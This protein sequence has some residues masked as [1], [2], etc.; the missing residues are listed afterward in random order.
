MSEKWLSLVLAVTTFIGLVFL[1]C[2]KKLTHSK[3]SKAS[4]TTYNTANSGIASNYLEAIAGCTNG[5]H[6]NH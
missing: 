4:W 6:E 2:S 3:R 1:G 5:A